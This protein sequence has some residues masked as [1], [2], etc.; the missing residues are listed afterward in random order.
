MLP[1]TTSATAAAAT[2]A[3][4]AAAAAVFS[5]QVLEQRCTANYAAA[6]TGDNEREPRDDRRRDGTGGDRDRRGF[7][8]PGYLRQLGARRAIDS[9][10]ATSDDATAN[11]W[12]TGSP[13]PL[14]DTHR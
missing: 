8:E 4:T 9:I 2:T 10:H 14:V 5:E 7:S 6:T 1:A 11:S 13:E 12:T 3:S